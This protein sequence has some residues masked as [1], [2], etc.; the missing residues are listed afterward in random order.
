MENVKGISHRISFN[1]SIKLL[2]DRSSFFQVDPGFERSVRNLKICFSES[3]QKLLNLKAASPPHLRI[4]SSSF[5]DIFIDV[6]HQ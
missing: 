3:I 5:Y 4:P 6:N 1:Q 2:E